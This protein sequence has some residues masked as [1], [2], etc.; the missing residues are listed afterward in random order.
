MLFLSYSISFVAFAFSLFLAF[1]F[2]KRERVV[3][4]IS[5]SFLAVAIV[6]GLGKI[7]VFNAIDSG[8]EFYGSHWVLESKDFWWLHGLLTFVLIFGM[9]FGWLS[10]VKRVNGYLSFSRR[11]NLDARDLFFLAYLLLFVSF[12]LR[13]LYVLEF[14]GFF[15]YLEHNR[16]LRSGIIT[17]SNPFSFL[18]PFGALAF[19]SSYFFWALL[20]KRYRPILVTIGLIFS[21]PF[22]LYVQYSYSGRVGFLLFLA[23]FILIYMYSR[24]VSAP[25]LVASAFLSVPIIFA[26]LF[27][28]SN[29]FDI[30]GADSI[31]YFVIK[32]TAHLYTSFFAQINDGFLFRGFSD[33]VLAPLNLLPSSLVGGF[34]ETADTT[35][36][37]LLYGGPKG[38]DGIYGGIPVDIITLGLMQVHVFGVFF[39]GFLFAWFLKRVQFVFRLISY[40]PILYVLASY[41]SLRLA[42]LGLLYAHPPHFMAGVFP[43]LVVIFL[44]IF[45]RSLSGVRN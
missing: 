29:Y 22:S 42:F 18:Q 30:K 40:R 45:V 3:P 34:F 13:Y 20:L 23:N 36:T 28:V 25:L 37:I 11:L 19:F 10:P 9:Y 7:I 33:F 12:I 2:A 17:V 38:S 1:W 31:E 27:F 44:M 24:R 8:L 35:N 39:V 26:F 14:G 43:L 15:A 16:A 41:V 5:W 21:V 6:Y 4:L 32:E